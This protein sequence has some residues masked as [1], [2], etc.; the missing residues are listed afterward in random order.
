MSVCES[1]A[2]AGAAKL[3]GGRNTVV[4]QTGAIANEK[5][6]YLDIINKERL[7]SHG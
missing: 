2:S 6:C 4:R 3:D 1:V 7:T 5:Q